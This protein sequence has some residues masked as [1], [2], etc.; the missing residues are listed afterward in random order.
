MKKGNI[1]IHKKGDKQVPK[2]YSP[3]SL[4]CL[5]FYLKITLFHQINLGSNLGILALISYYP[6]ALT[7]K[8]KQLTFSR[9]WEIRLV[10][11]KGHNHGWRQE[12]FFDGTCR[13]QENA[14]QGKK[15]FR[16]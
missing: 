16:T 10:F 3:I 7:R 13:T 11:T 12:I 14:I 8:L 6:R 1:P 4:K 5:V 15:Y 9:N 2:N